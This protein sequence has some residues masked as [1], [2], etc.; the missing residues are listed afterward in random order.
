[1]YVYV[2]WNSAQYFIVSQ[3]VGK[4]TVRI[5]LAKNV[6]NMIKHGANALGYEQFL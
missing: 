1:M 5:I 2:V 3:C 6:I 4:L